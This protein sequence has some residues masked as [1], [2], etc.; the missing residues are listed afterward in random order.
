[1]GPADSAC[2]QERRFSPHLRRSHRQL[3]PGRPVAP[4]LASATPTIS[5]RSTRRGWEKRARSTPRMLM[6]RR[7]QRPTRR[8]LG[9]RPTPRHRRLQRRDSPTP[10]PG[11]SRPQRH[12]ARCDR[13]LRPCARGHRCGPIE[14]GV[15]HRPT[16]GQ[17]TSDQQSRAPGGP[18]VT[19][20]NNGLTSARVRG[21]GWLG[22]GR[23]WSNGFTLSGRRPSN[24]SRSR[25]ALR[26]PRA[27]GSG[28]RAPGNTTRPGRPPP[29]QED[30]GRAAPGPE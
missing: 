29:A 11:T 18:V 24:R 5:S 2:D 6:L 12:Q 22:L 4:A 9:N 10:V 30:H 23:S 1:M 25:S 3:C 15:G 28:L 20:P 8:S 7:R 17:E 26:G 13:L 27:T 16:M 21:K 19:N 14:V